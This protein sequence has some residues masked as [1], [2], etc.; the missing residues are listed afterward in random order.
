[1]IS[2]TGSVDEGGRTVANMQ[3]TP[4]FAAAAFNNQVSSPDI[5]DYQLRSNE[6]D[7]MRH[8]FALPR[9]SFASTSGFIDLSAAPAA[10]LV[11]GA[12]P[13]SGHV[14]RPSRILLGTTALHSRP[15][16]RGV[17]GDWR[18]SVDFSRTSLDSFGSPFS[19][20]S[21]LACQQ[22]QGPVAGD[23]YGAS[24][25]GFNTAS[26]FPP[27]GDS[28]RNFSVAP[29]ASNYIAWDQRHNNR[30]PDASCTVG[31]IRRNT[32][33]ISDVLGPERDINSELSAYHMNNVPVRPYFSPAGQY[34][35]LGHSPNDPN[36]RVTD[37]DTSMCPILSASRMSSESASFNIEYLNPTCV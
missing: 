3:T 35:I 33:A 1:M 30:G 37:H 12:N 23:P 34:E 14:Q 7:V 36:N 21:V 6:P 31:G 10:G 22:Q 32:P 25:H 29:S 4:D 17:G 26:Y 20:L 19:P 27:S 5:V 24:A 15:D 13:P 18:R 16:S 8:S 9:N 2:P 11:P 28:S